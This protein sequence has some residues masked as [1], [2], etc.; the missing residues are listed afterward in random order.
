MNC[1]FTI[2]KKVSLTNQQSIINNIPFYK[3]SSININMSSITTS[4]N[5]S[6]LNL[7]NPALY[8]KLENYIDFVRNVH[9][10]DTYVCFQTQSVITRINQ[11]FILSLNKESGKTLCLDIDFAYKNNVPIY[12]YVGPKVEDINNKKKNFEHLAKFLF[13]AR[14][15]QTEECDG[16]AFVGEDYIER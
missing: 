1:F 7:Q 15:I 9:L 16:L 2:F 6:L 12:K 10:G 13:D 8:S 4:S 5:I 3:M 14:L 11:E